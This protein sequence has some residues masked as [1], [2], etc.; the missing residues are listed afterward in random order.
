[1]A[2]R[3]YLP[4]AWAEAPQCRR[5]AR[6]PDAVSFQTKP[7]IALALLDQARRIVLLPTLA[8]LLASS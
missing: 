5:K 2:V 3:L 8:V 1:M 4:R 7:E 6:V